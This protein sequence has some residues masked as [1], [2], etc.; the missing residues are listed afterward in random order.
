MASS[1]CA[2]SPPAYASYDVLVHQLAVLRPAS[3][4]PTLAGKPLP[5]TSSYRLL[6][7]RVSTVFYLQ[8]TFTS[9]VHAHAGRTQEN[10]ADV[11]NTRLIL[12]LSV[13]LENTLAHNKNSDYIQGEIDKQISSW[14]LF[15][16]EIL[17]VLGFGAALGAVGLD[18]SEFYAW[19]S[20]IFLTL[21]YCPE[22]Y[23]RRHLIALLREE[24]HLSLS[25]LN[26]FRAS[27]VSIFGITFLMLV[28][29]GVLK[30][31]TTLVSLFAMLN[32]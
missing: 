22:F 13:Y 12:A 23:K 27:G 28:A 18:S 4:G 24:N 8:R 26:T 17:G 29:F 25:L 3:S 11:K 20:V 21:I 16:N 10:Q 9:L 15:L 5:F 30:K 7:T 2:N 14:D 32:T 6:T 19:I 31:D 1:S